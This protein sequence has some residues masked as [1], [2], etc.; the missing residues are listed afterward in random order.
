M[1]FPRRPVLMV[2]DEEA[3]LTG[4]ELVLESD[5]ILN[6]LR[7]QDSREVE[8]ILERTRC[9][10]VLLDLSMP[11][12]SG[13]ELLPRLHEKHPD[14]PVIVVTGHN[15]LEMAVN[16]MRLGAFDYM[17]KPVHHSRLT[18]AVRRAIEFN[19]LQ[20]EY[21]SFRNRVLSNKLDHPDA[22]SGI[23]TENARMHSLFQYM[24]TI[25]VT[26]RSVFI[27]GET[28]TGKELIARAIHQISKRSG[29]FV[30][31][32][33]AGLDDNVFSDTLFGHLKGAFTGADKV[34]Q[35]L[36]HKASGGTLFLDEIGDLEMSSQVKLLR[37]LQENEY[38]PLGAD[39][40]RMSEARVVVATNRTIHDLQNTGDFRQD[41]YF[42]LQTHHIRI[43]P[44]R[45]RMDDLTVL[46]DHF[47]H[48]SADALHK[49]APSCPETLLRLLSGY[50]FPG[51]I[52]ELEAMIFESMSRHKSGALS[53]SSFREHMSEAGWDS[54]EGGIPLSH[55]TRD[56]D[57][58]LPQGEHTSLVAFASKLPTLK[59]V[60][61]LLIVE[62][63]RRSGGNQ[64]TA[65]QM[66]GITR[67]GLSKAMKRK[68]IGLP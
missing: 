6:L 41:L 33:V 27:T 10:A 58:I 9:S 3:A 68:K 19:D 49:K 44:L 45:E 64:T 55:D 35:G 23:I 2:D 20:T 4:T 34:R 57:A 43:P 12:L 48:K 36:I 30:A 8:K 66:L 56:P 16:C 5:G 31:V 1:R 50:S 25:A 37:L 28:G 61:E 59:E 63:L 17:T 54:P 52:R 26:S 67:S 21:K 65:A 51:N 7:C 14:T 47:L 60:Q 15:E 40:A 38:Y 11:R 62:A 18:S 46:A 22:F 29:P 42:R 53:F 39:G 24:E 32:N 13:E